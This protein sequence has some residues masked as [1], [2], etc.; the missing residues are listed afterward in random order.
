MTGAETDTFSRT[1]TPVTLR[2]EAVDSSG[3]VSLIASASL[4]ATN[5]DLG[6]LDQGTVASL[7]V[8]GLGANGERLV[9]GASL[10]MTFGALDG[11]TVPVF[12]QRTGELAR[13]PGPLSDARTEPTLAVLAGRYLLVGAGGDPSLALTTQ[14][15]DFATDAPVSS[16]PTLSRAPQSVALI[17]T[18][19]WLIDDA[20]AT[21]FDFATNTQAEV[22]VPAGGTFAEIA[23]GATVFA[24]DGLQYIVGATRGTGAPTAAVLAID[25]AGSHPSWSTLT[26]PRLGASAAWVD[27]RG[28][29]V[30]GGSASAAGVE[31]VGPGATNGS[32]LAYAPDASMGAGAA[33]LD[34]QHVLLAG[35]LRP[36]GQ[37]AGVR[38]IDLGCTAQC[39]PVPWSAL[40]VALAS[41][42]T[43]ARGAAA[44]LVIGNDASGTTHAC[45][46]GP[47]S[48][49]ELATKAAHTKARAAVSPVGSVVLFGGANVIESFAP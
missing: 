41:A 46:V 26:S 13:M 22:A 18:V 43:F 10:P 42:Q 27:G 49:T 44:A 19:A 11:L 47:T 16:P 20:G 28:L 34:S 37:D 38:A 23:G 48:S 40:P 24:N 6:K 31:V 36:S 7:Q 17:G 3:K 30:A 2:V 35:G 29:V 1:P 32:A 45:D 25:A 21:R 15:Y 5:V 8:S 14:L 9:F 12:V 33:P 39:T 4:P